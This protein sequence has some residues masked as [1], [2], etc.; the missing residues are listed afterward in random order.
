MKNNSIITVLQVK[1]TSKRCAEEGFFDV[2][3]ISGYHCLA[4]CLSKIK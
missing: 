3:I 4:N 2:V 1:F